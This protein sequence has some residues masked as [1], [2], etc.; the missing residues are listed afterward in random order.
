M[1]GSRDGLVGLAP[2]GSSSGQSPAGAPI[3]PVRDREV[4]LDGGGGLSR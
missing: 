3:S 2:R 4:K 1:G